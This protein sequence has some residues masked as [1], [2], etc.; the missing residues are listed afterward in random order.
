MQENEFRF[1]AFDHSRM[2]AKSIS[3]SCNILGCD[4]RPCTLVIC[5]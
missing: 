1:L 2:Y 3:R 5:D 4:Y